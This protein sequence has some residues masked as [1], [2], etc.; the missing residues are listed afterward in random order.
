MNE[1]LISK[2]LSEKDWKLIEGALMGHTVTITST[3]V[4]CKDAMPEKTYNREMDESERL[5]YLINVLQGRKEYDVIKKLFSCNEDGVTEWCVAKDKKQAYDFMRNLWG[6]GSML[7]YEK[8]YFEDNPSDSTDDFIEYFFTD[9][10]EN[11]NF[12]EHL[13]CI[14][15]IPSYFGC[16][17]Y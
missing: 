8:E 5:V 3:C 11:E 6:T 9:V 15:I 10:T 7:E 13:K 12:T 16:E 1:K 17:D 2:V 14:D 4:T